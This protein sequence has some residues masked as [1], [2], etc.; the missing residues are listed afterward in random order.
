MSI[1][2]YIND[3]TCQ[4]GFTYCTWLYAAP[5]GIIGKRLP[6]AGLTQVLQVY[7]SVGSGTLHNRN[8]THPDSNAGGLANISW[9]ITSLHS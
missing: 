7:A 2:L 5:S 9:T 8:V 3:E 6:P 1:V 4:I